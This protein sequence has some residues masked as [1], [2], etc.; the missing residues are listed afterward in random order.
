MVT[1]KS[2]NTSVHH[3]RTR[4]QEQTI[5][6]VGKFLD[7]IGEDCELVLD[8]EEPES[9]FQILFSGTSLSLAFD[10]DSISVLDFDFADGEE[11][12]LAVFNPKEINK[13]THWLLTQANHP[14]STS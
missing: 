8:Y 10:N 5:L 9:D 11:I 3:N 14:K 13:A 6:Q 1:A 7:D 12:T 4:E 2:Y